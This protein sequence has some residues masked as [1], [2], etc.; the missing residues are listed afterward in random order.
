MITQTEPTDVALLERMESEVRLYSRTFPIVLDSAKGAELRSEDGRRYLDFFCGACALNFGHNHEHIKGRLLEYLAA[1][2]VVHAMDMHTRAKREFLGRLR[3]TVIV[4]AGLDYRVQFCGPTGT[5]AVEAALKLARKATRRHAVV[6]F[7]GAYHGMSAG[8]LAV[9]GGRFA[10]AAAG[11][12]VP[13]TTFLPYEDGPAAP[14]D[15]VGHLEHLLRDPLS[16]LDLPA[17]VIVEPVQ[18]EGGIFPASGEWL[19]RLRETTERHGVLLICDEIQSGCGRT[20][21]F[22]AFERAGIE[23]DIVTVSKSLSGYGLPLSIVLLRPELD[24]WSA[25]EHTG[26]FRANQL[27]LVASTAALELWGEASL[28]AGVRR[29]A[30]RLAAFGRDV[31]GLDGRMA[32]RGVGMILGIDT[33]RAGGTRRARAIQR[34]CFARGLIV[35]LCGRADVVVKVTPPLT[36]DPHRLETGITI[37]RDAILATGREAEWASAADILGRT[38]S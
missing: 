9:S 33:A 30:E 36:I 3:E 1:D 4:P 6:A 8:S 29:S 19:R 13:G 38:G 26:T 32:V 10:R 34:E 27:A 5:N 31:A 15:S 21:A 28:R 25:G 17:A 14:Y 2:G 22:F 24:V 18:M 37:L 11:I 12:Q 16:G 20:G 23:P 35:E 7:T